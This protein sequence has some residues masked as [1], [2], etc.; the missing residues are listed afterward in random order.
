VK[1]RIVIESVTFTVEI[2][3]DEVTQATEPSPEIEPEQTTLS[4]WV[5]TGKDP[6]KARKSNYAR[7][8]DWKQHHFSSCCDTPG[9]RALK[10]LNGYCLDC[11]PEVVRQ[12]AGSCQ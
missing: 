4:G 10:R 6:R 7:R 5:S 2:V 8:S 1:I 12:N 11:V 9:R 3:N